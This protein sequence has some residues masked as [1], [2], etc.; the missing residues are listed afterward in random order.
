MVARE[1]RLNR[2]SASVVSRSTAVLERGGGIAGNERLTASIGLA[3]VVLLAAEAATLTSLRSLLLLHMSIGLV[4]IPVV[5]IKLGSAGWRFVR[6][7]TGSAAYREKGPPHILLRLLA[8][9]LVG[10]TV[11]LLGTGVALVIAAPARGP[12]L[13]LHRASFALWVWLLAAHVLAHV[14]RAFRA[15][16]ADLA[17]P[18]RR[19]PGPRMRRY[20]VAFAL[21]AGLVLALATLPRQHAWVDW[22]RT[23]VR[24]EHDG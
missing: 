11:V 8:P 20:L 6:Y 16:R 4:I 17:S 22:A 12:L 9:M 2:W 15:T 1:T 7:Y 3:L 5:A 10:A 21:V 14:R 18:E 23:H 24:V 19:A 13:D